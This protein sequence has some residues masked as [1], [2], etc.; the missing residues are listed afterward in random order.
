MLESQTAW[1]EQ[2]AYMMTKVPHEEANIILGGP[3]ALLKA[4]A[5]MVFKECADTAVLLF[6]GNG[7]TKTGQG[8]LVESES[9]Q[10]ICSLVSVLMMFCA[11]LYRE[12]MGT[13]IPG[14]SEDVLLDLAVR[15][16]VKIYKVQ[17]KMLEADSKL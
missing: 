9:P 6:G 3:T 8:Q 12:V 15:Q 17:T 2:F 16:L 11:V 14:G 1:V 4:H 10:F 7:Y 5:G 13:R